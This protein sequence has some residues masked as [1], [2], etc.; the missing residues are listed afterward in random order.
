MSKI[1]WT[2]KTWNPVV[3]CSKIS[4]GCQN[5]YAERM[6]CRLAAMSRTGNAKL[7][8]YYSVTKGL[9]S[10]WLMEEAVSGWNGSTALVESALNKPLHWRNPRRVFVCSM[11]DLFHESVPWEWIHRVMFVISKCQQH[12]F[13]ILTKRPERMAEYFTKLATRP[14]F[15]EEAMD[16]LGWDYK[17]LKMITTYRRGGHLPNL[18]LGTTCENQDAADHRIPFLLQTPAAVRFVS[19]EPMLGPVE[20]EQ[21]LCDD[22]Y[23]GDLI[24]GPCVH[25]PSIDWVICGGESGPGARPMHPDWARSLRDQCAAT[26]TPFMFKQW[27]EWSSTECDWPKQPGFVAASGNWMRVQYLGYGCMN[28]NSVCIWRVG[29]KRAGRLLD[30]VGHDAYPEVEV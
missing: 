13:Q 21:Y 2:D 17:M 11:G 9:Y 6:A 29:K 16:L 5:C 1:E 24:N 14:T 15:G 28:P 12:T 18:W 19:V 30:G 20:M 25:L 8:N 22:H 4:D 7:G 23:T 27:G 3:G 10:E 26:A